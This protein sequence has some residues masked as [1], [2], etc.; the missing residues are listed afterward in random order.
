MF[1]DCVCIPAYEG[2]E[3]SWAS[4]EDCLWE[5]PQIMRTKHSLK[6]LYQDE[7]HAGQMS[8]ITH[9]FQKILL[10]K[11]ASWRHLVDE[12]RQARDTGSDDF[13]HIFFLYECLDRMK[14][15]LRAAKMR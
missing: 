13:D 11:N 15:P 9:L 6:Y 3:A 14:T 7:L 4:I 2:G 12:L 5:A 1:N 8:L 10:V